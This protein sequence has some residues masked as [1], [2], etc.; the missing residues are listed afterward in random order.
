[1][2]IPPNHALSRAW[3]PLCLGR[4]V[5]SC[6]PA[7][8]DNLRSHNK[9]LT[10]CSASSLILE[11]MKFLRYIITLVCLVAPFIATADE[12]SIAKA[13]DAANPPIAADL[14]S[15]QGTWEG[16]EVGNQYQ[17]IIITITGHALHFHRDT[18]FWF[19][20]TITL[21]TGTDPKQLHATIKGCPPSQADSIGKVARA[22]FK[23][24]DGTLTLVPISDDPEGTPKS[25]A[26]AEA[27]KLTRYEL[28]KVKP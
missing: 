4:Q 15:L 23:I 24:E 10:T 9:F 5:F 13:K 19:E 22:I 27:K 12:E 11:V 14:Q 21:P 2:S 18:N 28:Q 20:T 16:G 26:D 25:F 8:T 6:I 3:Y 7:K 17:K 1:M